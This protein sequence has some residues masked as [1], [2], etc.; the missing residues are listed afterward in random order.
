MQQVGRKMTVLLELIA[1]SMIVVVLSKIK[2]KSYFVQGRSDLGYTQ[3]TNDGTDSQPTLFYYA[4]I[5]SLYML[6]QLYMAMN[7]QI[8]DG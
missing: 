2:L 1:T 6:K 7:I 4:A 3:L 5:R 8:S